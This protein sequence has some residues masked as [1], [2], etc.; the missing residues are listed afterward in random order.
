MNPWYTDIITLLIFAAL[1]IGLI[2]I[3]VM[4]IRSRKRNEPVKTKLA[5]L[6]VNTVLLASVAVFAVSH[7]TYYK[8]ND[9]DIINSDIR[10][11]VGKYG[12]PDEGTV[13]D[14]RAGKIGYYIYTDNGPIMPDHL[15]YYYWI[16]YD[17]NGK[18]CD[19]K[20][21]SRLGA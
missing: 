13:Q 19:I 2:V 20:E 14:G 16:Y 8:Y 21:M 1:I 3:L 6:S 17:E 4:M 11:V 7:S 12:D 10:S 5:A 9:W 15:Q 18:V